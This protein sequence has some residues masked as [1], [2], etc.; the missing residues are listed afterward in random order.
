MKMRP[1][2]AS[3]LAA[4]A[5]L[6]ISSISATASASDNFTDSEL[7]PP[8]LSLVDNRPPECPPCFNCQ[9]DA[10]QCA[11]FAPCNKFNG[12]CTCGPGFGGDDCSE[13]LCGSLA[14]G[15]NRSPRKGKSCECRDGW[16]GINCNVCQ[17][18]NACSALMPENE[19]GV[20]YTQGV[21]VKENFQMCDVTNKMILEQLGDRKPQVTFSCEA[22]DMTC[23][24]QCEC[25]LIPAL[26]TSLTAFPE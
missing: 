20:C 26:Y 7:L 17:S 25:R 12:K 4:A 22:D 11:Q 1:L 14:D 16:A 18:D 21:T 5:L 10:F 19:G 6:S 24:F 9:L 15:A 13:P 2:S 8:Y 3:Q 23:N